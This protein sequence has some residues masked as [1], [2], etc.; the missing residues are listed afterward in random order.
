MD[1]LYKK[2][3]GHLIENDGAYKSRDFVN[4]ANYAKRR[5][6]NP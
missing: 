4:F 2:Y 6:K 1:R 3:H 5:V